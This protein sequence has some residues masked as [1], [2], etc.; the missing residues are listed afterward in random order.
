MNTR[1]KTLT[2]SDR[3]TQLDKDAADEQ[4]EDI[5]LLIDELKNRPGS[6]ITVLRKCQDIIGYL[7]KSII[8]RIAD[9]LNLPEAEVFG[10]ASFYSHFLF[11]PKGRN[12]IKLCMGTACYVK[13]INEVK[14]RIGTEFE[15]EEGGNT[16][17]MRFSLE[18]VR[19]IGAC[20][21]APVMT[22]NADTHAN[23]RSEQAVDILE[24]YK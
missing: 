18:S 16:K 3:K 4:L 1:I 13:G 14:T 12:K 6:L 9:G 19:C 2:K 20:S 15:V 10:V 11:E 23:V 7:P 17:D 5:N 21:L 8:K 24:R 22:V